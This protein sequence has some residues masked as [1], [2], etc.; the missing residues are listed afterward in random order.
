MKTT[1]TYDADA[2]AAMAALLH[3]CGDAYVNACE[4]NDGTDEKE[5]AEIAR[6]AFKMADAMAEERK[7]QRGDATDA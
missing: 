5:L 3:C 2:R 6:H 7:L 4:R 1:E